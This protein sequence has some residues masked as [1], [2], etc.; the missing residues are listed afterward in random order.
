MPSAYGLA[1]RTSLGLHWQFDL[2][3]RFSCCLTSC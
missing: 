3:Y 2:C 1:F